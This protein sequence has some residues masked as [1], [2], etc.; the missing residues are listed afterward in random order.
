MRQSRMDS[1]FLPRNS[2]LVPT[3][4]EEERGGVRIYYDLFS[5]LLKD[6]IIFIS[7]PITSE[8]S[9]IVVAQLLYL[10]KENPK[11]DIQLY[12]ASPGGDVDAGF[13]IL[14]T[15]EYVKCPIVTI[16]LGNVASFASLLLAAG[17]QGKRFLLPHT[18]VMIHQP[19]LTG[20]S[21]IDATELQITAKVIM[22]LKETIID[23]LAEYTGKQRTK[24]AKDV[25]RDFW[26]DAQQAVDY[27]LADK[28]L[29]PIRK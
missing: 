12:I 8:M 5:R 6:R 9:A 28:V 21:N 14:D 24:V 29:H 17:S 3:V 15:M 19:W 10:E 11:A 4:F 7:G 1:K 22:R 25:E 16:G 23:L 26:M 13:A 18:R 27:G 20:L 2:F